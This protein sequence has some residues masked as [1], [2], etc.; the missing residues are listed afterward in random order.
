MGPL[1][2]NQF[3]HVRIDSGPVTADLY[4]DHVP[5][6]KWHALMLSRPTFLHTNLPFDCRELLRFVEEAE[7]MFETLGFASVEDMVESGFELEPEQVGW[8]IEGLQRLRP[9][10]PIPYQDAIT[11]GKHGVNQHTEGVGNTKSTVSAGGSTRA[12]ILARLDRDGHADLAA[13]VRTKEISA[14]AAAIEAGFR[15]KPTHLATILKLLPKLTAD[16]QMELRSALGK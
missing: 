11:L 4:L 1:M 15:S 10:E 7:Q 8:A 13:K 12:Y 3:P 9:N 6:E 14:N 2:T 5:R 16:D